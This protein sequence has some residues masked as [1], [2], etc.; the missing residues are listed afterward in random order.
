MFGRVLV[1][2]GL[3]VLCESVEV[4]AQ[5]NAWTNPTSGQWEDMHWSLGQLPGPGQAVFIENSGSKAVSIGPSTVQNFSQTV[6]PSSITVSSPS[7]SHNALVLDNAGLE[8]PVSVLQLRIYAD[9]TLLTLHSA[10]EVNNALGGAFSIG[11]ALNQG[12]FSTVSTASVQI[13]DVGPGEY[14]LTNGNLVASAALSVGGN[15]PA[16]FNQFGG[17]NYTADVQLYTSGEYDLFGGNLTVSNIIYRPGSSSA[18][19]FNQY[20]GTVTGGVVYVTMGNYRLAGGILSCSEMQLPGV[21]S[22]F[23]YPDMANFL[24]AGGTNFTSSVSIGNFPPPYVNAFPSGHYALSNGV[25]ITTSTSLGPYG[26]MEQYGGVHIADSLELNGGQ[27]GPN[28]F[29]S[30]AYTLND[31]VLSVN[32]LSMN[33]GNFVQKG[34]QLV[35]P[36]IEMAGGATFSQSG[37]SI[38]NADMVTLANGSWQANTNQQALGKLLVGDSQASNSAIVFPHGP[39]SLAFV[40]SASVSWSAQAILTIEH[41]NGSPTGDGLHQ[42]YFGNDASGLS[43]QQLAQI[44]F[45]NPAGAT[46]NYPATILSTGEIVPTQVLISQA[47]SNGLTLSWSPGF[48]LQTSTNV[49]GLFED[50]SSPTSF[51]HTVTFSE[52]MRFFRLRS[53]DKT[54]QTLANFPNR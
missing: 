10:L 4:G 6:R 45:H 54:L 35:A 18:G 28:V 38:M 15:F 37:G 8:M 31:G 36:N 40:N 5:Q 43:S 51:T 26:S 16:R 22:V 41:W 7:N 39:S 53:A 47:S 50:F 14:N 20:G 32:H 9:A 23:D 19:N 34:G 12:D 48:I 33:L 30:P 17:S 42:L 49:T 44:Q 46:G 13:G 29:I 52:P 1:V 11:G 21:T 3:M 24:Q 27:T 2:L 25:L